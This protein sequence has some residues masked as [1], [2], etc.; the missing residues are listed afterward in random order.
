M[1]PAAVL[2]RLIRPCS[3]GYLSNKACNLCCLLPSV[4]FG[5]NSAHGPLVSSGLISSFASQAPA[6]AAGTLT[7]SPSLSSTLPPSRRALALH[8]LRQP[9]DQ[10][11]DV[12]VTF[13][14]APSYVTYNQAAISEVQ[15]FFSAGE[16][17]LELSSL[18]AQA[19][20]RTDKLRNL[21]QTQLNAMSARNAQQKPRLLL[22]MTLHAP[23]V[24][25]PGRAGC[26][27]AGS[28]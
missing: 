8:L 28:S 13:K 14:L 12:V 1:Q 6:V 24:A 20:A 11:A 22:S 19:A 27:A 16:Q 23:K 7:Q 3:Y 26:G 4:Q 15:R 21:A 25:I 10:R 2:A 9:Q 18:Q 17:Q 5:I